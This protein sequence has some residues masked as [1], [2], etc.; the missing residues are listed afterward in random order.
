MVEN[1]QKEK[2]LNNI[3]K[4]LFLL[5]IVS[6]TAFATL[7]ATVDSKT[8]E[9][10][11]TVTYSLSISGEKVKKPNIQR[12]CNSDV[13]STSSQTSMQIING[14]TSKSYT[15]SYK[16][17]PQKSCKIERVEVE[18]DGKMELSSEIEI[19]V[20]PVSAAKD[21]DF[22]LELSS[23]KK[24][25]YVG[26]AFDI[27]LTFKQKNDVG[28]VDS[29]FTPPELKGLWVKKESEPKRYQEDKYTITKVVYRVAPQRAG[30]LKI[31]KA[32]MRVASRNSRENSWGA[33]IPTIKWKTYFSNELDLNVKPLPSGVDLVGNFTIKATVEKKEIK[34]NEAL[35]V[36]VEVQ[37]EGNLEDIKSFKQN[38]DTVAVFDEKIVIN[39]AKLT[40]KI[41]FVAE[42]DFV[43]PA[44]TLNYFD[45]KTKEIKTIS[46][47][48]IPIKVE[49]S[50]ATQEL[51]VKKS[52]IDESV[53]VKTRSSD[54]YDKLNY[55][56]IFI[57]GL[58]IGIL[59][60]FFK[61]KIKFKKNKKSDFTDNQ[62]TFLMK[63]LP[64]KDD[65][66]AKEMIEK[67]EAK[68]YSNQEIKLDKKVLKN[69]KN[70]YKIE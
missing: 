13:L 15:L 55:I 1:S 28:A 52:S 70:K 38:I 47:K 45:P 53:E 29:E 43:V 6:N 8:V 2:K 42:R 30:E 4:L 61:E 67:L 32:Q 12:L 16:F 65:L 64:F 19:E 33:W 25:L 56:F 41:A 35:N 9:L 37:G 48:E 11:E 10:G 7:I 24:E 66:E 46:T 18:V 27:T 69:I 39:G 68:I 51:V 21:L 14:N 23:E 40:Q 49:N 59:T 36:I 44:F 22:T 31:T 5:L 58:I 63:L 62:K 57:L 54:D 17:L 26:E 60:M 20:K 50:K 3:T 34:A